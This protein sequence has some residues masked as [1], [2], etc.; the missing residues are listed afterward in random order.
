MARRLAAPLAGAAL[1]AVVACTGGDTSTAEGE[2]P[3]PRGGGLLARLR[4]GG[5]T[6]VIRHAETDRSQPDDPTVD[7]DDCATQRNLSEAGRADARSIGTAIDALDIPV[8]EVWAS[9]YCRSRDT[10]ELAFGRF[11]VVNGLER[12]YPERDEQAD[13]RLSQLL[14]QRAPRDGQPNLIVASHG[15]YPSALAPPAAIGEGEAALYARAGNGFELVDRL[16]PDEWAGLDAGAGADALSGGAAR[17]PDSVVAVNGPRGTGSAF[18]VAVPGVLVTSAR[19]VGNAPE[20]AV[21]RPDGGRITAR[22]LGL[23]H[24]VDIAA[25]VIDDDSGLPPLHSAS[26][27]AEARGGDRA[28]AIGG[29][30]AVTEGALRALDEAVTLDGGGELAAIRLDAD[31]PP[32]SLGG[33]LVDEDGHVLG[34]LTGAAGGRGGVAIPVDVARSAALGIVRDSS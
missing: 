17:V 15:V 11:E 19:L 30:G 1:L 29:S 28:F 26:G 2:P 8:G 21:I 18:R 13:Q 3:S 9:P 32:A 16:E 23:R 25:L 6:I 4:E 33:P 7:L 14:R 12:L 34:V 24:D 20:V 22:V 5:L 27:L 31:A 10:A